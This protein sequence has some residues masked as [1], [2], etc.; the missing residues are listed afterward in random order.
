MPPAWG[1]MAAT[2]RGW[3]SLFFG[4]SS[5]LVRAFFLFPAFRGQVHPQRELPVLDAVG[6]LGVAG[7]LFQKKLFSRQHRGP[8]GSGEAM[9]SWGV[10]HRT[11]PRRGGGHSPPPPNPN[12]A[13]TA[14]PSSAQNGKG[15]TG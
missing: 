2:T 10:Q 8:G 6:D 3:E 4:G 11:D 1:P 13:H 5:S 12:S 15:T 9:T 7:H 14:V